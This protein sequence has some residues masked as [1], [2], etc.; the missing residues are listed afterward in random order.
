[1]DTR[2][3]LLSNIRRNQPAHRE[4]PEVP[5]F[6]REPGPLVSAFERSL[7]YMAGEF[8]EHP[9]SDFPLISTE[10]FR[11]QKTFVRPY[12]NTPGPES[13]KITAIGRMLQRLT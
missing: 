13:P 7:K 9:P 10:S 8:V 12:Q 5:A 6:R 2:E 11:K 3:H 4:L 1:M